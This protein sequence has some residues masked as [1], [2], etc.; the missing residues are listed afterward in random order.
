MIQATFD[1]AS[2]GDIAAAAE[3]VEAFYAEFDYPIDSD[4][5]WESLRTLATDPSI[6][7]LFL[8]RHEGAAI[9][10]LAV[11]LGFSIEY[12]GRDAFIDE[13]YLVPSA[14]GQGIG[15]QA[16]AFAVEQCRR[17]GVNAL[18]LEV[19][20]ANHRAVATYR[21]LGFADHDRILMTRWLHQE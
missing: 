17:E 18:H 19:E 20:H 13:L 10:Y 7:R 14:R 9:G 15:R 6:G 16:V 12:R 21:K 11:T 4:R 2:E 1:P 8:I 3:M 5:V